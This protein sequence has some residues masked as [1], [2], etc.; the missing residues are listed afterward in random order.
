MLMYAKDGFKVVIRRT[1]SEEYTFSGEE[2]VCET[3]I[4]GGM[5]NEYKVSTHYASFEVARTLFR[6]EQ[7]RIQKMQPCPF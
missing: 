6:M 1:T 7:I 4:V 2:F 5:D 3:S